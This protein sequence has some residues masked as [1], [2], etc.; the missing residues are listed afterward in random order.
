MR[1]L[2]VLSLLT[3]VTLSHADVP[4]PKE[5]FGHDVCEDYW[6]AN[7]RQLTAYWQELDAKSDRITVESI[8][9]TEDGRDQLM[10]VIT[11]PANR[12][13]LANYRKAS[14]RLARAKDFKDDADARNF[15]KKQKA[16]IWIDGGLHATEV[17]ATQQLIETAHRLVSAEDEE[18]KRIRRD[19]IILL[20]HAN[21]DGMDLVSDFYMRREDP[22]TRSLA[23]LPVLYQKYCGHDNNRDFYA[24]NM[25]ETRNVNRILY[26][27]W[28][29]QIVYNH[30]QSAPAGT[31]MFVPPFRNPFN[32]HFDPMIEIG[33]D[34]VG[35]H[36]HQRMIAEGKPGTAMR[37]ATLYSTWW[38]GG[39]RTTTY[40]H[41][42][43]GILTETWGSPTPTPLPFTQR[44]QVPTTDVPF[45]VEAGKLW[46]LRDSLEYEVSA[47]YA[48][49]DYASR[50]R[51]RLLFD[52]YRAARNSI[53]RG[54]RDSWTRYPSRIAAQGADALKK[55]ELRDARMYV[56]PADQPDFPT[57]C[58]FVEKLMQCGVEVERLTQDSK[59]PLAPMNG[60]EKG[61]GG[62]GFL[63]P[64]GSFVVRCDQAFRPHI[65]DMFEPQDHPNDFQ[66]PG[67]PPIPP[68]DNAGYT[69]AYQMGVKFE[70]VLDPVELSTEPIG[71]LDSVTAPQLKGVTLTPGG[72]VAAYP[73]SSLE[74][75]LRANRFLRVGGAVLR[76]TLAK[77]AV[78]S[79]SFILVGT[80]ATVDVA[81][82]G[83]SPTRRPRVA[84]WDRY[85][86]SMESGWTRWVLEQFAFDFDV[87]YAP[88]LDL[89][90]L[91]A[92]YDCIIFPDGAIP[93]AG[94]GRGGAPSGGNTGPG[95]GEGIEE[96]LSPLP[97]PLHATRDMSGEGEIGQGGQV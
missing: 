64:A 1:R 76:T 50:Y 75:F 94:G 15:A 67:G 66:Y 95:S 14:E 39:L 51:E 48:I 36:M 90:D 10:C 2:A 41:N 65:L 34:L 25:A 69:L 42:M 92:K 45:P 13:N 88:D 26:S 58:K 77:D 73:P 46:H 21:P 61:L 85:G 96:F 52:T 47:N 68:Y 70:R 4:S 24:S 6:L 32:F 72:T 56:I 18:T 93:G 3:L 31:I 78:P 97:N 27:A 81:S 55:P 28:Y 11:D 5:F 49:L 8:G 23:G 53:E 71:S 84:L 33:T 37:G 60:G 87:V 80:G 82:F 38:N 57:A 19:C 89:G 7:Y 22:K 9:K 54:S 35:T 63:A 30:H 83:A 20:A 29:P 12:R 44:F 40:F 17:L 79:G 62:E 74:S 86:G 16:V 59:L 43:I 91:N